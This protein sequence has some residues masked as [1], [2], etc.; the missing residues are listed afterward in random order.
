M[1]S[2]HELMREKEASNAE[3]KEEL[4]KVATKFKSDKS[5]ESDKIDIEILN[6]APSAQS[7]EE[8]KKVLPK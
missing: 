6:G 8:D 2:D 1:T 4:L 3:L 7:K 5:N